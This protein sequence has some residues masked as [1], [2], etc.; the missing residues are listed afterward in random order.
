MR[1]LNGVLSFSTDGGA[2]WPTAITAE[3][4]HAAAITFGS[5]PGGSNA[6]PNAGFEITAFTTLLQKLWDVTADWDDATSQV[7][8]SVGGSSLNMTDVTY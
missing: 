6:V 5:E 8:L 7:N 4:I 3:G 1:W 2:T